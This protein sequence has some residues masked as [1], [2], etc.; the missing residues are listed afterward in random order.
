MHITSLVILKST[1]CYFWQFERSQF[2]AHLE[3]LATMYLVDAT[4]PT[5]LTVSFLKF[6]GAF[7]K[8]VFIFYT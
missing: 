1:L 7:V 2:L 5:I 3:A 8:V 6:S 4:P